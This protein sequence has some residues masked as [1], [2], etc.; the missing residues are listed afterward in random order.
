VVRLL[1]QVAWWSGSGS[2]WRGGQDILTI[3]PPAI[4]YSFYPFLISTTLATCLS[5]IMIDSLIME[6]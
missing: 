4:I 6:F 5:R 3:T 1:E 2:R